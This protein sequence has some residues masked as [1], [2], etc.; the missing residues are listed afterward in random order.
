MGNCNS[1]NENKKQNEYNTK[2]VNNSGINN[3]DNNKKLKGKNIHTVKELHRISHG[4]CKIVINSQYGIGF[5][6]SFSITPEKKFYCLLTTENTISEEIIE[7]IKKFDLYFD[8]EKEK[9]EIKFSQAK[10]INKY[11]CNLGI[12]MIEILDIDKISKDFFIEPYLGQQS[13]NGEKIYISKYLNKEKIEKIDFVGDI[14]IAEI[15]DNYKI[16]YNSNLLQGSDGS[17]ILLEEN[18]QVIGIHRDEGKDH[19]KNYGIL[20]YPFINLFQDKNKYDELKCMNFEGYNKYEYFDGSNYIGEWKNGKRNGKGKLYDKNG[21]LLYDGD[22]IN[23]KKEGFGKKIEDDNIYCILGYKNDFPTGEAIRYNNDGKIIFKG[24]YI[25]DKSAFKQLEGGHYYIGEIKN[26]KMS[27]KGKQYDAQKNLVYEG[28]FF[29]DYFEGFGRYNSFEGSNY[30][31]Y[32]IGEWKADKRQGK[33][34]LYYSN[35]KLVYDGDWDN[36]NFEGEG[37]YIDPYNSSYYIGQF[38]NG[39]RHGKGQFFDKSGRLLFKGEFI[40]NLPGDKGILLS[41]DGYIYEGE[42][43]ELKPNGEGKLFYENKLVYEGHFVNGDYNGFGKKYDD[44]GYVYIGIFKNN[45]LEGKG[46]IYNKNEKLI[47][48]GD[49]FNG[50]EEGFGKLTINENYYIGEFKNGKMNGKGNLY[51]NNGKPL[52]EGEWVDGKMEGHGKAYMF[53]GDYYIGKFKDNIMDGEGTY[54]D[55]NGKIIFSGKIDINEM[56]LKFERLFG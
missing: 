16:S 54:Y 44:D 23:D 25:Y 35:G 9:R 42:V 50:K 2:I 11:F 24:N 6:L 48:E 39:K 37:K 47:Y 45:K 19:I 56:L 52:Y 15:K 21:H 38:K 4:I 26:W 5:L 49:F 17:P 13:F 22:W 31:G 18:C 33:G 3:E 41:N 32:Y 36:N 27:G 28:D 20:I 34:K 14:E 7:S 10:R 1:T 46:K 43:K 8:F 30:R 53:N 40:N 12:T 55:K 29:D 51:L